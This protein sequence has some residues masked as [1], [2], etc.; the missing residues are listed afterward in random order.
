MEDL[1]R[2]WIKINQN[3]SIWMLQNE[4]VHPK[5]SIVKKIFKKYVEE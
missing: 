5:L 1:K 3:E 2:F 4:K